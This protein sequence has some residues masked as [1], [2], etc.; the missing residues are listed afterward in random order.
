M[1]GEYRFASQAQE[2]FQRASP[3]LQARMRRVAATI[4]ARLDPSPQARSHGISAETVEGFDVVYS[5]DVDFPYPT[6][7]VIV[8]IRERPRTQQSN[9]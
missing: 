8:R 4:V 9:R 2:Q 7:L 3:E 6:L 1:P 5:L